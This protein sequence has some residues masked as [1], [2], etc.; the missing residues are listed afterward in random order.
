MGLAQRPP[1]RTGHSTGGVVVVVV[2]VVER[3]VVS[4]YKRE[5]VAATTGCLTTASSW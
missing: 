1:R 5:T 4:V 3:G 2:V